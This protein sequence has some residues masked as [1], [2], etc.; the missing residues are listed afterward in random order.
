MNVIWVAQDNKKDGSF[1]QTK[2]EILCTISCVLFIKHYYPKFKT[3]LFVDNHTFKYYEQFGV[4]DMFDNVDNSLLNQDLGV[5]LDVYW[6]AGKIFAQNTF[7]GPTLMMDL[8]F[9]FFRDIKELNIFDSDISCLWVETLEEEHHLKPQLAMSYTYLIWRIP[10]DKYL[11]N[12]SFLFFQNDEVRKKYCDL[13]ISYMKSNYK[14]LSSDM[15]K[16]EK[17]K[18]MMFVEQYMLRQI[19]KLYKQNV[20]LLVDDFY[21]IPNDDSNVKSCGLNYINRAD[22]FIHYGDFKS[23]HMI[24]KD[25][26]CLDE[27]KNCHFITNKLIKNNEHLKK[28]NKVYE[29]DINNNCFL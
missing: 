20:L 29:M 13:A 5:N 14:I 23:K 1:K 25:H 6:A 18:F 10:W 11:F 17:N 19:S 16:I 28:F 22:Y 12:T 15:S 4:L 2:A 27:I 8:D 9:R 3:N 26:I 7:N 21:P 24:K